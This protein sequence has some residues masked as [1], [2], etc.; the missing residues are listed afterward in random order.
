MRD[1]GQ[2]DT[3]DMMD[4]FTEALFGADRVV[5]ETRNALGCMDAHYMSAPEILRAIQARDTPSQK[6]GGDD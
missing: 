1:Q 3:R 4:V 6:D 5:V 2:K